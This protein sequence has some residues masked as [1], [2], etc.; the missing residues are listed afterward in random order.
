MKS[1]RLAAVL[2]IILW[3]AA[4]GAVLAQ[5][6]QLLVA[7]PG[8]NVGYLPLYIAIQKGYFAELGLDVKVLTMESGSAHTN[9]VL[10]GQAFAFI[11]GPEHNAFA[12]VKGGELRSVVN[13]VNRGNV[14]YLSPPGKEP[15]PGEDMASYFKGKIIAVSAFGGTPNSITRYL[16]K[17]WNLNEKTDVTLMEMPTSAVPVTIKT[18]KA[19]IGVGGEPA[20]T[21]GIKQG[22]W[23]EPFYKIPKELGPYAYSTINVRLDSIQK[24]PDTVQKFVTAVVRGIEFTYAHPDEA[25]VAARKEFATMDLADLKATLDRYFADEMWTKDGSISP[26]SWETA[27]SVVMGAGIL[28]QDVA[29]DQIID[30]KFFN[31][32]KRTN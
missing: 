8:H 1:F 27:K 19:Q 6:K 28:K 24:D 22:F 18:G 20:I 32:V 26:E 11:G 17:K 15:K 16:L 13:V 10:S 25:A 3:P 7:E 12:K 14:Y 4:P 2:S 30:M 23:S 31:A 5:D 9:A 21:Q 29:Y